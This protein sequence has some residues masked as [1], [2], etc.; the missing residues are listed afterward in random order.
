MTALLPPVWHTSA[1]CYSV[2]ALL[3]PVWHT[4]A[5]RYSVSAL[6]PPVWHTSALHYS[7]TANWMSTAV[8]T[9]GEFWDKFD[10][11]TSTDTVG[12]DLIGGCL[13]CRLNNITIAAMQFTGHC[14]T[15]TNQC[16]HYI[17]CVSKKNIPDIFSCNSRKHCRIFIMFGTCYR[18]SKQ[19]VDA[20]VSHRT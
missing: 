7:M 5:P 2:S 6:L 3:P 12:D 4:S 16:M 18:E 8:A 19:S 13:S 15:V 11:Y 10:S 1:P 14:K 17:Q 9:V 20:I